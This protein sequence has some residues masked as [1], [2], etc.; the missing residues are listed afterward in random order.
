M[1]NRFI[2]DSNSV[3]DTKFILYQ[4]NSEN[5]RIVRQKFCRRKGFE[6]LKKKSVQVDKEEVE[7]I[8]LS[9]TRRNIR[10]LALS[11]DF[12]Y[13]AT[14]T[15]NSSS[16]DRF[17][18]TECQSKLRTKLQT[19]KKYNKNF[20]YLFITEK[21]KNGAYHFHG[22]VK[23]MCDKDLYINKF[24]Y[25]S[26]KTFDYLGFNSFS[27]IRDFTKCC[28]YI[29]KYI[30]KNCVKNEEGTVY[31]S[32]RGLK[33]ATKYEINPVDIKWKYEN[34]FCSISDYNLSECDADLLLNLMCIEEIK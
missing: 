12:E 32:S 24:G 2:F 7:R 8:S 29:T 26:H 22:L 31:I 27:K 9:R 14:L 5:I 34:E 25:L 33:K 30:T 15:I 20:A 16:C 13:F 3:Y 10:E 11:N 23:G 28:N 21:H 17:S 19:L 18:L 4:Y 1:L 6:D